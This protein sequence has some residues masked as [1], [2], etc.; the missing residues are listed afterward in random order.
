RASATWQALPIEIHPLGERLPAIVVSETPD[1]PDADGGIETDVPSLDDVV[2]VVEANPIAATTL[3]LL[4]RGA[5]RRTVDDGLIAE[6]AGDSML[7]GGPEVR[8]WLHAR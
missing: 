7:P 5:E 1:D 4:L 2:A 3:A 8:R 6:A